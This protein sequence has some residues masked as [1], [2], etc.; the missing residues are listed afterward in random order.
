M[1]YR[2]LGKTGLKASEIGIG[3]EYLVK[4]AKGDIKD[5]V[6][7]AV[8]AGCNYF[9]I[10]FDNP[11]YLD[12][13]GEA[14]E[15]I[16]DKVIITAHIFTLDPIEKCKGKFEDFLNR[17]KCGYVDILFISCCDREEVYN[18]V[19]DL[20]GKLSD[21][22]NIRTLGQDYV[23]KQHGGHL[24]YAKEL[25]EQ[26]SVKYLGFS[27]HVL[28]TAIRA[29]KDGYFDLLMFPI[30]PIFD[31]LHGKA[32]MENLNELWELSIEHK[33]IEIS[34]ERK[35]LHKLCMHTQTGLI[36][37]KPFAGG[38]LLKPDLNAN[39]TAIKLLSYTLSQSGVTTVIPGVSNLDQLKSCLK[40]IEA[41][42][43][44]KDFSE[45]L[46]QLKWNPKDRCMYCSHCQPCKA[47]IDIAQVNKLYDLSVEYGINEVIK[48]EYDSLA[49]KAEDCLNCGECTS[50]CPFGINVPDRMKKAS[51]MIGV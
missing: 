22:I 24:K 38:W 7:T 43:E 41:S 42:N 32:G 9:D 15:G 51:E 10:L 29:V 50:R 49:S 33:K 28:P 30:N 40:Y 45:M 39:I 8:D 1:K 48:N 21:E 36:A 16:R 25:Q 6:K 23:L 26:G 12:S 17:V 4:A 46:S 18:A 13:F 20:S 19:T 14:L 44:E 31:A 27:T 47:G 34:E 11:E 35:E 3:T 2:D 37:M 5:V